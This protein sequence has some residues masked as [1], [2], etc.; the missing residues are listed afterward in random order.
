MQNCLQAT[1]KHGVGQDLY[2]EHPVISPDRSSPMAVDGNRM[3]L[4][5][6]A[7]LMGL[8]QDFVF[9]VGLTASNEGRI[10]V[11]L[12]SKLILSSNV[13][14][15]KSLSRYQSVTRDCKPPPSPPSWLCEAPEAKHN[16]STHTT[17][18]VSCSMPE[19]IMKSTQR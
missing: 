14:N 11:S 16:V 2:F 15:I 1:N 10:F 6:A 17:H 12:F 4:L 13:D 9:S 3:K 7:R 5:P 18:L 19:M 8:A